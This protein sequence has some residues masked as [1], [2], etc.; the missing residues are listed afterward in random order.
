MKLVSYIVLT[1]LYIF[2]TNL[3]P[4][5]ELFNFILILLGI[6]LLIIILVYVLLTS[7]EE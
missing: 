6:V 4:D 7:K 3:T 2:Q 1:L 5:Q